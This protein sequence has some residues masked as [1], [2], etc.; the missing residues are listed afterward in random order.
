MYLLLILAALA[1]DPSVPPP[2]DLAAPPA[3]AERS[4]D[5]L[6]TNRLAEGAGTDKPQQDDLVKVRYTVWKADGSLVQ[7][8]PTPRTATIAVAKMIPGWGLAVQQM[9]VGERQR[10]WIPPSLNGGKLDQGLVFDTE[11]VEIIDFPLA[12]PDVAAPPAD[13]TRTPSGLAFKIGRA[14]V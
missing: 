12:P 1:A 14:H 6:V 7:H 8:V 9:L 4:D 5:G 10:S 3:S 13:A 2:P 11:L